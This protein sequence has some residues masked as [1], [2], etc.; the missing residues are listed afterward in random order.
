MANVEIVVSVRDTD[1]F[2]EL[3]QIAVMAVGLGIRTHGPLPGMKR[4][5]V[6]D[7]FAG[8]A[9]RLEALGIADA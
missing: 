8:L 7:N 5:Q 6:Y 1:V 3:H 2:R 4:T 9:H